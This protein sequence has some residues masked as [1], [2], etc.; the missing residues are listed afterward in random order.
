MFSTF[1]DPLVKVNPWHT[2]SKEMR[3]L[4]GGEYNWASWMSHPL[5]GYS[6]HFFLKAFELGKLQGNYLVELSHKPRVYTG[7]YKS[8]YEKYSTRHP[9]GLPKMM[10][11][12]SRAATMEFRPLINE[13]G[14]RP[15][16]PDDPRERKPKADDPDYTRRNSRHT[17]LS[18]LKGTCTMRFLMFGMTS[19]CW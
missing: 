6:L 3:T 16:S 12:I 10:D 8:P 2:L 7:G 4:L 13:I 9:G 18:T 19:L 11:D 17:R 15:P 14:F 1:D 5:S